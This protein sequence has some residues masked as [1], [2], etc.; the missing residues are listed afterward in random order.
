LHWHNYPVKSITPIAAS[1]IYDVV[2]F[3]RIDRDKGIEDLLRAIAIIK[4]DKPDIK[5]CV[6]G[7]GYVAR[8]KKHYPEL[9]G[10]VTWAGC[11]QAQAD[12]HQVAA[13]ARISV[14]PTYHDIIPGTIIESLFLKLPVVAYDVGSIHE[15]NDHDEVI[16]L[17]KKG[18]VEGLA[19]A[20]LNLLDDEARQKEIAE[21]GC[22]RA[23]EMFDNRT[24]FGDLC[25]AYREVVSSFRSK[26][27]T[28]G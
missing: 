27:K 18:D 19:K 4:K 24:V 12:V 21:K 28:G 14:L 8:L 15:V 11:L 2:F 3:A 9:S 5:V 7:G 25:R 20:M 10:N 6:I 22:T 23:G 1:K 13:S 16:T 17:V 26:A